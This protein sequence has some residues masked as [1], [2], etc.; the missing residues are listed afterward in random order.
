MF[1]DETI[2][3]IN[4][5][6]SGRKRSAVSEGESKS[7]L[8]DDESRPAKKV[9]ISESESVDQKVLQALEKIERSMQSIKR[10]VQ[11]LK[12]SSKTMQSI[13][14]DVQVLKDSSIIRDMNPWLEMSQTD[15]SR[16]NN[17]RSVVFKKLGINDQT[18]SCWLSGHKPVKVAHILPC[19]TKEVVWRKLGLTREFRNDTDASRWNFMVLRN[20]IESAFDSLKVSFVP[21]DAIH[22][23][24]F[25]LRIWDRASVDA[26]IL[27]LDGQQ[28][29]IPTGVSLS[30][31][32]LSYQAICA[33]VEYKK[34]ADAGELTG[35]LDDA[36]TDFSS[37]DGINGTNVYNEM[38]DV[39]RRSIREEN[40]EEEE[41]EEYDDDRDEQED[42]EADDVDPYDV[43][44]SEGDQDIADD[45]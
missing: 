21:V 31:R 11:M 2:H 8:S 17:L 38:L 39:L 40:Q 16:T 34:R 18:A 22:Q 45:L 30:R 4:Q 19:S 10:D 42:E 6:M 28:L 7:G 9:R 37:D 33:Y 35:N 12:D 3:F 5:T 32:A 44:H 1:C 26:A 14:R 36:P 24:S 41:E 25:K 23:E 15:R 43:H 29:Q 13:K 27:P 20:D